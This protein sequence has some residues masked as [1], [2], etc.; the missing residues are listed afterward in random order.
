MEQIRAAEQA[1]DLLTCLTDR[2]LSV[3]QSM[4]FVAS[5]SQ[6]CQASIDKLNCEW[7]Q[8]T[9][10]AIA[11]L[12][13]RHLAGRSSRTATPMD[14]AFPSAVT[15]AVRQCSVKEGLCA[16]DVHTER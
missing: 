1:A 12:F 10:A 15:M 9:K 11:R 5:V 14:N 16:S 8:S 13:H 6:D 2:L 3:A 7:E 4:D